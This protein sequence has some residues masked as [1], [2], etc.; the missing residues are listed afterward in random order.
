VSKKQVWFFVDDSKGN[1]EGNADNPQLL[2]MRSLDRTDQKLDRFVTNHLSNQRRAHEWHATER[3]GL[4]FEKGFGR[5]FDKI[6]KSNSKSFFYHRFEYQVRDAKFQ[7]MLKQDLIDYVKQNENWSAIWNLDSSL[8][9]KL[10]LLAIQEVTLAYFRGHNGKTSVKP[11]LLVFVVD[12]MSF[13]CD[14]SLAKPYAEFS[15]HPI[16]AGLFPILTFQSGLGFDVVVNTYRRKSEVKE[17]DV[18]SMM[19]L[20]DAE[21]WMWNRIA[22]YRDKDGK[23]I[24]DRGAESS[25]IE[26]EEERS[27]IPRINTVL[28]SM[29]DEPFTNPLNKRTNTNLLRYLEA[30]SHTWVHDKCCFNSAYFSDTKQTGDVDMSVFPDWLN[31]ALAQ[32][33]KNSD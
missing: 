25:K 11:E 10:L 21:I 6:K 4:P 22:K 14:K 16:F 19:G 26:N 9:A 2:L 23:T 17:K 18:L 20:V 1:S 29:R 32:Y 12:R 3:K 27:F 31:E 5:T 15:R 7:E 8:Q 33:K 24:N 28:S 30:F 13:M